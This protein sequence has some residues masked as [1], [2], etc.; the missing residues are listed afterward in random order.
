[1]S[2]PD[3]T[4]RRQFLQ[5]TAGAASAALAPFNAGARADTLEKPKLRFSL[6]VD[7]ASFLPA[8]I[9]AARTWHDEGLDVQ[10]NVF[11]GDAQAAQALAGGSVDVSLQSVDGLISLIN[12]GQPVT[13]FY[14]GFYQADFEWITLPSIKTWDDMRGQTAGV[15]TFGSLTDQ[16]TRYALKKHGLDPMKDVQIRQI[17]PTS[18]S[19]QALKGGRLGMGILSAPFKWAA[20]EAGLHR[21]GVQSE[22]IAP[23]WPKHTF[24]TT[25]AFLNAN[26]HTVRALLRAHVAAI[27]LA[28]ADR[29]FAVKVIQERLKFAAPYAERAYDDVIKGFNERGTL[30]P[31]MKVFWTL[32]KESG[33]VKEAWPESKFFDDRYVKTFAEWAPK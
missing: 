21:L 15:S 33:Q 4:T 24:V 3:K 10:L 28:R 16:L 9:A 20:V 6:S 7:A 2:S 29:A 8:Y 5:A 27:R 32:E 17:G 19:F 18:A 31:D 25:K 30:P 26:P 12:A 11:R 23:Q 22:E 1:M 13:G 14:A